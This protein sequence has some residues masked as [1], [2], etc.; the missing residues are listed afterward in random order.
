MF[1]Q[2]LNHLILSSIYLILTVRTIVCFALQLEAYV[3]LMVIRIKFALL[4][5][6][7]TSSSFHNIN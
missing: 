4:A 1:Y 3:D 5:T 2:R 7:N 6:L